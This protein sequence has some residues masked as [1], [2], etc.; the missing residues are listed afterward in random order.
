MMVDESISFSDLIDRER[1]ED[2]IECSLFDEDFFP[3]DNFK[4]LIKDFEGFFE[5]FCECFVE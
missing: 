3:V 1:F 4:L 5:V 2:L